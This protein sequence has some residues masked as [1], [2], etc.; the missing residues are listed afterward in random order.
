MLGR[1]NRQT[2]FDDV[3]WRQ[4]IPKDSYWW[5]LHDWAVQNLDESMFAPL[6]DARTG[7]PS[8]SPVRT[9]L[10]LLIQM[11]KGYSD[12][13]MEQESRFDDRV[14]LAILAGRDFEGIDAVTLC[15]HRRRFLQHGIAAAMLE[16]TLASAKQAGLFSPER[17]QIVDSFLIHGGAAVQD[18]YTLIRKGIVRVLAV[19]RMHELDGPLSAV[20]KRTDYHQPGKPRIDWDD[21]EARRQLLQALVDDALALVAAAR[22]LAKV[23][24]DLKAMV[25]LLERVAT[26]D[27]E[28]DPDGTVRLKQ[29][30]AKDRVI[31]VVDPE[32]RHG[33]KTAS[34]R[35]DG[36][37]AHLMTGG[38]GHRLVTAVAVTP[39]N[40]PDDARLEAM[41]D[42]QE[43]HGHRP[44]EVLGDQAYFDVERARR[45]AEKGPSSWPRRPGDEPGGVLL[46]GGLRP[47][48]R[49]RH[50]HL[51]R[52]ADGPLRP[53]PTAAPQG[54]RGEL[55]GRGLRGLSP[56]G[57]LHAG[58]GPSGHDPP[59]RGR[60]AAGSGVPAHPGLSGALPAAG[61]HR[62]HRAA[63]QDPRGPQ[64]AL[65]G[66]HQGALPAPAGRHQ[67]QH[68]GGDGRRATRGGGGPRMSKKLEDKEKRRETGG[69]KGSTT[70]SA[71]PSKAAIGSSSNPLA[72]CLTFQTPYQR[73]DST[74]NRAVT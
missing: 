6:F 11:E 55:C 29:G 14:K 69:W 26:Q 74:G 72:A 1:R 9:F 40:A 46:E 59:L 31:S 39:A 27:I 21:A 12:R 53:G 7:R 32:M 45:Q 61:P 36:Y 71:L 64:G 4:R 70:R 34:N 17:S 63:A 41:L 65:L 52:R 38:E 28:R 5:R 37:E 58:G 22:A 33:H 51:P 23:P 16:R 10:A 18:T 42:D 24:E 66:S 57:P 48:R 8:V 47:G 35:A 50:A 49:R 3:T 44:A 19:A 54:V 68:Q 60:A 30:V 25:D 43:R 73:P 2:T 56:Q 67:P 15:D 20:L 13:E 62:A